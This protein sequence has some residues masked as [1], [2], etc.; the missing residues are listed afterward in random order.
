MKV[1]TKTLLKEGLKFCMKNEK[2]NLFTRIYLQGYAKI[3][4]EAVVNFL[5]KQKNYQE[6]LG[7]RMEDQL[8]RRRLMS[9]DIED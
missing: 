8:E 6:F 1:K 7:K 5:K 9:L 3:D 4:D 2:P